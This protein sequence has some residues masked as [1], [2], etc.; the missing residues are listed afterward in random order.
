MGEGRACLAS[1]VPGDP[2][3]LVSGNEVAPGG[4]GGP[5]GVT[6]ALLVFVSPPAALSSDVDPS[7]SL[8]AR[9]IKRLTDKIIKL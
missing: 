5:K 7:I 6:K 2:A 8:F 1:L 9:L 4:M 3:C